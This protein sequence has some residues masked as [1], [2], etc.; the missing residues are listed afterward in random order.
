MAHTGPWRR[1]A[2]VPIDTVQ[3]MSDIVQSATT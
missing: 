2:G 3:P 1:A